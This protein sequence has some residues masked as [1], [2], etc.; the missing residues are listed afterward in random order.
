MS[1]WIYDQHGNRT[2]WVSENGLLGQLMPST[3]TTA[4]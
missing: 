3:S 2:G 1:D 4:T